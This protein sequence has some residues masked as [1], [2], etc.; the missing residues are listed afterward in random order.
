MPICRGITRQAGRCSTACAGGL[1][2]TRRVISPGRRWTCWSARCRNWTTPSTDRRMCSASPRNTSSGILTRASRCGSV[3]RGT[4][5]CHG[6]TFSVMCCLTAWGT[7]GWTGGGIPS[8]PCCRRSTASV[9]PS[10]GIWRKHGSICHS[11][12]GRLQDSATRLS[13]ACMGN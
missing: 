11:P 2:G 8:R 9:P 10:K 4:G 1:T 5:R 6:L 13:P 7:N 3:S 12:M